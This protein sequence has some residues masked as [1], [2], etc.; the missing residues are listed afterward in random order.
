MMFPREKHIKIKRKKEDAPT[1]RKKEKGKRKKEE[2]RR[3]VH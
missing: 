2:G 1:R 3:K